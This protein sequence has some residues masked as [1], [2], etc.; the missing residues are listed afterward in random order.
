MRKS[1]DT[2]RQAVHAIG[3]GQAAPT[4]LTSSPERFGANSC[5]RMPGGHFHVLLSRTDEQPCN[6]MEAE[7]RSTSPSRRSTW[8]SRKRSRNTRTKDT[9]VV[10]NA[11]R[12]KK[13][14]DTSRGASR[15]AM[16]RH[17]G[18]D[19]EG[20][21]RQCSL[22]DVTQPD[23][24]DL[25]CQLQDVLDHGISRQKQR[26]SSVCTKPGIG[27]CASAFE[28]TRSNSWGEG[29]QIKEELGHDGEPIDKR[30][31]SGTKTEY[32]FPS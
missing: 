10:G 4:T 15:E 17:R 21:H 28:I 5:T 30:G 8:P 1:R 3:R 7:G 25:P 2:C 26:T 11:P 31:P 16:R 27:E 12:E 20:V 13:R 23:M 22:F 14:R 6:Q 29:T 9:W 18:G 24:A 19:R 32:L